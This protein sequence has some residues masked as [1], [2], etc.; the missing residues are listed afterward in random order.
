MWYPAKL[1]S[2]CTVYL[3]I[4][5]CWSIAFPFL[6]FSF[7]LLCFVLF[8]FTHLSFLYFTLFCFALFP[9]LLF[10]LFSSFRFLSNFFEEKTIT[11]NQSQSI[12][13]YCDST[14][15]CHVQLHRYYSI[16]HF[17]RCSWTPVVASIIPIGTNSWTLI[18]SF[19]LL[20]VFLISILLDLH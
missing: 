12:C 10:L 16:D 1:F 15:H 19:E 9:F 4:Q 7:T 6:F 20:E 11:K 5:L 13:S 18:R 3:C 8:C 2:R 14:L 17:M